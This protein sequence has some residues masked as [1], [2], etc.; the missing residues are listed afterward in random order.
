MKTTIQK[1]MAIARSIYRLVLANT[2]T[3]ADD[4]SIVGANGREYCGEYPIGTDLAYLMGAIL[5]GSFFDA[6]PG[7]N[8]LTD[9]LRAEHPRHAANRFVVIS[10]E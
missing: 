8:A 4:F 7:V 6:L 10:I 3:L 2:E 9:W 1:R 5:D